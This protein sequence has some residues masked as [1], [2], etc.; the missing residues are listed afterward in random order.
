MDTVHQVLKGPLNYS[1]SIFLVF[2]YH[3]SL[4]TTSSR[5]TFWVQRHYHHHRTLAKIVIIII[6]TITEHF[7]ESALMTLFM[8]PKPLLPTLT[9]SSDHFHHLCHHHSHQSH[10]QQ[11]HHP[12]CCKGGL[13]EDESVSISP[14][15]PPLITYQIPTGACCSYLLHICK[16]HTY[17]IYCVLNC[18]FRIFGVMKAFYN[19]N[20][21]Q[22]MNSQMHRKHMIAVILSPHLDMI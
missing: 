13:Q 2:N 20:M 3:L 6:I 11:Q 5:N 18:I 17:F 4:P 9:K 12:S 14:F 7:P 21:N 22:G 15:Y 8:R 1:H 10:H 19:I 16:L